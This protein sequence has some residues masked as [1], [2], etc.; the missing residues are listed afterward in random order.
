MLNFLYR[1]ADGHFTLSSPDGEYSREMTKQEGQDYMRGY[2]LPESIIR[3]N[4]EGFCVPPRIHAPRTNPHTH[5]HQNMIYEIDPNNPGFEARFKKFDS[6]HPQF[7]RIPEAE[8]LHPNRHICGLMKIYAL[9]ARPSK[10]DFCAEHDCVYVHPGPSEFAAE[11][12][13]ADI[14]YLS[15]CGFHYDTEG[16]CLA[17]FC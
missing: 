8:R 16:D 5:L 15:R 11:L 1:H 14:I 10:L 13:D 7:D 12:S 17:F 6:E 4:T 9:A 3:S 2:G